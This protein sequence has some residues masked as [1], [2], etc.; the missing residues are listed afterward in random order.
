MKKEG[1]SEVIPSFSDKKLGKLISPEPITCEKSQ[2]KEII[3][4]ENIEES[5]I[6]SMAALPEIR[7]IK[8]NILQAEKDLLIEEDKYKQPRSKKGKLNQQLSMDL[9]TKYKSESLIKKTKI[10]KI[11]M[12]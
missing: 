4:E 2:P 5:N 9:R 7:D 6:N 8:S 11:L 1:K 10:T 3:F 12:I